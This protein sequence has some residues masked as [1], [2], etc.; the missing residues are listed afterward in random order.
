GKAGQM[1][2][3]SLRLIRNANGPV[4]VLVQSE[5]ED[6]RSA[7]DVRFILLNR[8]LRRSA[9]APVTALR[10]AAAGFLP[11]TADGAALRLR[12]GEIRVIE[13]QVP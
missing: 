3:P 11:V 4:S 1:R 8:D 7:S 13:G 12:A 10:E 9:P 5:A 2:A 6:L